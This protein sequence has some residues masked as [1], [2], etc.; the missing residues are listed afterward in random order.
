M[1]WT[2]RYVDASASGGGT[3]TSAGDPWTLAEAFS[4][5]GTNQRVNIKA[6]TYSITSPL[7]CNPS[8]TS[9]NP[10]WWRGYKTTIGDLDD[11]FTGDLVDGTDI[12]VFEITSNNNYIILNAYYHMISGLCFKKKSTDAYPALYDRRAFTWAKNCRFVIEAASAVHSNTL[13]V[14][15]NSG[16]I[17]LT[18]LNCEFKSNQAINICVS[19]YSASFY[20]DCL[21]DASSAN[22]LLNGSGHGN[23]ISKCIFRGSLVAAVNFTS[24]ARTN[25]QNNTFVDCADDAIAFNQANPAICNNYFYNVSGFCVSNKNTAGTN[26]ILLA[27]NAFYNSPNKFENMADAI[28]FDSIADSSDQ[29]VDKAAGDYSLQSTSN[30]YSAGNGGYWSLGSTDYADIGAIQHADPSGGGG[31]TVHPLYAN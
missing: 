9:E 24:N 2:D 17:H 31:S 22:Y 1:A 5:A 29:F 27:N 26:D 13:C 6:G 3:G 20:S 4:N 10:L 25:I 12:P 8:L 23:D 30:A 19:N 21:F 28:E 18:Y 15:R 16:A 14:S 11:K 7:S